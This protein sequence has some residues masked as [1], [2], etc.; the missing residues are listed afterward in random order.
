[1]EFVDKL[2][3]SIQHDLSLDMEFRLSCAQKKVEVYEEFSDDIDEIVRIQDAYVMEQ[4]KLD[5]RRTDEKDDRFL[6][7][8]MC[9]F[10]AHSN[11]AN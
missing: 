4:K 11:I 3:R 5:T 8:F 9:F 1:M 10:L 2:F 6:L 7:L